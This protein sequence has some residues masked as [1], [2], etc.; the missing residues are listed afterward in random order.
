MTVYVAMQGNYQSPLEILGIFEKKQSA[1][2]CC[3][4][5]PTRTRSSWQF[6]SASENCWHNGHGL[7]VKISEYDVR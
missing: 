5:Q 3:L 6:D 4:A 2:E 7:F 1:I